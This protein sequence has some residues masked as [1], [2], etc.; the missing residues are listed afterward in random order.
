MSLLSRIASIGLLLCVGC[1]R[2][3]LTLLDLPLEDGLPPDG[4]ASRGFTDGGLAAGEDAGVWANDAALDCLDEDADLDGLCDD[5]D[6][7]PDAANA[8]QRDFDADGEGDACDSDDDGDGVDD[9][10]DAC[11]LDPER[12][13]EDRCL[14]NAPLPPPPLAHWRLDESAGTVASESTGMAPAGAL[15]NSGGVWLAG[16]NANALHL[17][18]TDDYVQI[19]VVPGAVKTVSLWARPESTSVTTDRTPALYPSSTGPSND[20]S[21][22]TRAYADD[23]RNASAATLLGSTKRQHWGGFNIVRE[24]PPGANVLGII[25][26]VDTSNLGLLGSF[27]TELSWDGGANHTNANYSWG[28][29][30]VGSNLRSAGGADKLWGRGWSVQ[31]LDD[32]NFRVRASFGGLVNTMNIDYL[33]LEVHYAA[34]ENPRKLLKLSDGIKLE[35]VAGGSSQL[36]ISGWP[37]A[38]L[39]VNG[40]PGSTLTS[41]W[42]HVVIASDTAIA[43]SDLQLGHVTSEYRA[44]AFQGDLDDVLLFGDALSAAQVD[45]LFQTPSC[46]P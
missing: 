17:D 40:V 38:T 22:P 8:D 18:G 42:N 3:G 34:Y 28:Q 9:A 25:L 30:I 27:G 12:T 41:G 6:N 2:L 45:T 19:G 20:W 46:L 33:V 39:Y 29:L 32:A 35:F 13:S 14:C 7:C 31:D 44:F 37:G 23:G 15:L 26:S 4:G 10:L 36:S 21:N 11:P 1:G 43:V 16:P 5:A 24:L